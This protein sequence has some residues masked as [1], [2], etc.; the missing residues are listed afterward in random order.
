MAEAFLTYLESEGPTALDIPKFL[1][2]RVRH[3]ELEYVVCNVF[4]NETHYTGAPLVAALLQ[5]L[6]YPERFTYWGGSLQRSLNKW[7]TANQRCMVLEKWWDL[8]PGGSIMEAVREEL[9]YILRGNLA[10]SV[11]DCGFSNGSTSR[12]GKA[13]LDK[14]RFLSNYYPCYKGEVSYPFITAVW[15]ASS[16]KGNSYLEE[17]IPSEAEKLDSGFPK[18]IGVPKSFS[19]FR[20]IA[21]EHPLKNYWGTAVLKALRRLLEE[22]GSM[23]FINERDQSANQSVAQLGAF[24]GMATVDLSSASDTISK[25]LFFDLLPMRYRHVFTQL[26]SGSVELPDGNLKKLYSLFTSGHPLTWLV[27]ACYFLALTRVAI[28][29]NG[30]PN[31]RDLAFVYGDDLELP[32]ECFQ[33]VCELLE[34]FGHKVNTRKSYTK[35]LFR[36]SCGAW[37]YDGME[38]T[39][40]FWPRRI[41]SPSHT[42]LVPAI[43]EIQHKTFKAAPWKMLTLRTLCEDLAKQFEPTMTYSAAFEPSDDLWS[44]SL[45]PV[46]SDMGKHWQLVPRRK[47][48]QID[49]FLEHLVYYEYLQ[50]GPC[51]DDPLLQML[52]VS[53]S[54]Y[55][56]FDSILEPLIKVI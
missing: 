27:E 26:T 38:V 29:L 3:N 6:L 51:Y 34:L 33:T 30:Y 41:V 37:Y 10:V 14:W 4:L 1:R 50:Y 9:A 43:C 44:A 45:N 2:G 55:R 40:I 47:K 8:R 52:G 56:Q 35:G 32:C 28:R 7:K 46:S 48:P 25:A 21:P 31:Y 5:T 18:L 42:S 13:S 17:L 49:V 24:V 11:D 23:A 16:G 54:R 53:T 39:P 22:N 20:I 19:E 36:E 15:T 12:T